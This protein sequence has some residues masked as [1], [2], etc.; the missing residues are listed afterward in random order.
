M[1]NIIID[2]PYRFV[3]PVESRFWPGLLKL[4]LPAVLKKEHGIERVRFNNL[5]R[6]R[7]SLDAGHGIVL[8]PNHCRPCD[9]FVL[10]LLGREIG[11]PF[12]VMASW[13]LFMQG[14]VSRWLLQRV[15]AFSIY[16]EGMDK[17]ALAAA[18]EILAEAQRP[19]VIFP[20]GIV[21]RT[22]DHLNPLMDGVTFIARNAA[23]KS[24]KQAAPRKIVLHAVA[25]NYFFDGEINPAAH[26]VLNDIDERLAWRPK[27]NLPLVERIYKTGEALLALKETEHIGKPRAGEFRPRIAALIEHLLA[28]LE[29]EYGSNARETHPI[30]RIKRLRQSILPEMTASVI[31]DAERERR[32]QQLSNLYLA[33]QLDFYPPDYVKSRP[34]PE[35]ILE[36]VE[37]FEEDLTDHSRV[38]RPMSVTISIGEVIEASPERERGKSDPVLQALEKSLK[39]MLEENAR[40]KWDANV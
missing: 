7:E 11:S 17:A 30:A 3:P 23:K 14:A 32:W 22:N 33:Q 28:P 10:G 16:R 35:R 21:S 15:G 25:L 6:L 34:T 2:K 12:F 36:T 24:L 26:A 9:P 19:L 39:S 31:T 1:Q 20:E 13:H 37:R 38:H 4:F 40:Q 8:A 18:I 27:P 5:E 29:V